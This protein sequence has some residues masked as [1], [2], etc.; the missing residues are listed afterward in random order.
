MKP[1]VDHALDAHDAPC[2]PN[3]AKKA[4]VFSSTMA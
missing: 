1:A 3:R 2:S 4:S